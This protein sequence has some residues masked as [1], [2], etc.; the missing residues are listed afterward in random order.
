[1]HLREILTKSAAL[2]V[3]RYVTSLSSKITISKKNILVQT[4]QKKSISRTIF[5]TVCKECQRHPTMAKKIIALHIS[6][7]CTFLE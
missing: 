6:V 2:N 5:D 3:R 1:M 7:V 4:D